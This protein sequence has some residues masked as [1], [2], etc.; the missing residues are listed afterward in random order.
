MEPK[1]SALHN[2]RRILFLLCGG[3]GLCATNSIGQIGYAQPAN[4]FSKLKT[5]IEPIKLISNEL[6]SFD[7][8]I[9]KI[10]R[11]SGNIS[12]V[13]K[14]VIQRQSKLILGN[15]KNAQNMINQVINELKSL[16]VWD[17]SFDVFIES[18]FRKN[19][20][21]PRFITHIAKEGGA[22]AVMEKAASNMSASLNEHVEFQLKSVNVTQASLMDILIPP[23]SAAFRNPCSVRAYLAVEF[24]RA[25]D[26]VSALEFAGSYVKCLV[27]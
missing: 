16:N 3:V 11:K 14:E 22:R 6:V 18:G 12:S 4:N 2:R 15:A 24:L 10:K 19:G 20:A 23:A 27:T 13:E 21:D 17:K 8:A 25:G 1:V 5:S 7:D 26:L 9:E